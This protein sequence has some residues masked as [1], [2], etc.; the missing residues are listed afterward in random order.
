MPLELGSTPARHGKI[1]SVFPTRRFSK[2][3]G[4]RESS[5]AV[6][7][8]LAASVLPG[9]LSAMQILRSHPRPTEFYTVKYSPLI[10]FHRHSRW[11]GGTLKPAT[12]WLQGN[13]FQDPQGKNTHLYFYLKWISLRPDVCSTISQHPQFR[14]LPYQRAG[15]S[16]TQNPLLWVHSHGVFL[17]WG[18]K[19]SLSVGLPW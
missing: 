5:Q 3:R 2:G 7:P 8:T 17:F 15:L 6:V 11:T 4:C 14:L 1:D 13:Q 16:Q 12:H 10:C 19:G 18:T 9:N